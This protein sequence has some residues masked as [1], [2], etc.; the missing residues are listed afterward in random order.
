MANE[1]LSNAIRHAD[2]QHVHISAAY[3]GHLF[4]LTI[5]DDGKGFDPDVVL[6]DESGLGLRNMQQRAR[7]HGGNIAVESAPD[8]GTRVS[9]SLPV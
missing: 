8:K 1:A 9:I 5:S 4:T 3:S 6:N 7:L 2:A